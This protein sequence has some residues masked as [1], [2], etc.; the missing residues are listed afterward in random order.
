M[1]GARVIWA[2]FFPVRAKDKNQ[3]MLSRP[4]MI[5]VK[6]PML[7]SFNIRRRSHAT[8]DIFI[9]SCPKSAWRLNAE[10][11]LCLRPAIP[12]TLC[13]LS[14]SEFFISPFVPFC[15][16]ELRSRSF[17]KWFVT[18]Y[19]KKEGRR[20]PNRAGDDEVVFSVLVFS[21]RVHNVFCE[22]TTSDSISIIWLLGFRFT[23]KIGNRDRF[24][25]LLSEGS[26]DQDLDIKCSS[27]VLCC[28]T[29]NKTP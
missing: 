28:S 10:V 22:S 23:W 1:H 17:P 11:K 4:R 26:R 3:E 19:Q 18:F 15:C 29:A 6:T 24:F 12:F 9:V 14:L 7:S 27:P 25:V 16:W 5:Y 21:A 20:M 8:D 2:Q 13:P